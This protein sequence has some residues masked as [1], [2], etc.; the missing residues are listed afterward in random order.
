MTIYAVGDIH[1][2]LNLLHRAND[3]IET[4]RARAGADQAQVIYIGDLVDR[5]PD[6]AGV[7][8]LLAKLS[9]ADPRITVLRGNHDH[10]LVEFLDGAESSRAPRGRFDYLADGIGGRSTLESYGLSRRLS[11]AQMRDAAREKI[12]QAHQKFLRNLPYSHSAQGCL[13][14]HAG[15]RPGIALADQEPMDLIW[16]REDF[17]LD[18]RDHGPLIVHGHTPD[19]RATH[20]GNRVNLDSGAAYGGPLSA[21]VIENRDA[22]LLTEQGRQRL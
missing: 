21:V 14:V 22:F 3:L 15:I 10:M 20:W 4:D 7:V 17:L 2:H 16:I 5:G 1:G 8:D 11:Q 6:S 9:Q 18:K 12:P 13:F 19:E